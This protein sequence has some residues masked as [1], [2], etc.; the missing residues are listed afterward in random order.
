MVTLV[1]V[2]LFVRVL[3]RGVSD[4]GSRGRLLWGGQADRRQNVH[5][6][7]LRIHPAV[8]I[9]QEQRKPHVVRSRVIFKK[10]LRR[11]QKSECLWALAVASSRSDECALDLLIISIPLWN[12]KSLKLLFLFV[13][14]RYELLPTKNS[15]FTGDWHFSGNDIMY[16]DFN[17]T[18]VGGVLQVTIV[19]LL[20]FYY[21]N[22]VLCYCI[23]MCP[24]NSYL[25][26]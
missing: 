14:C 8:R 11:V 1:T 24:S 12:N 23:Y 6:R 15:S 5:Q 25:L 9:H 21:Y 18:L 19:R 7:V 17:H 13:D 4:G 26:S 16:D 2:Y 20:W 10:N 22:V 3:S